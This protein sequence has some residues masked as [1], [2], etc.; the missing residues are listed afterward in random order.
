MPS[1]PVKNPADLKSLRTARGLSGVAIA[2][3]GGVDPST[4]SRIEAGQVRARPATVVRLA[5][6]LGVSP[7]RLQRLC[8]AHWLAAHPDEAL[9]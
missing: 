2:V 1:A 8:D 7:K 3:L 4:I 5:K 9:V 6:A